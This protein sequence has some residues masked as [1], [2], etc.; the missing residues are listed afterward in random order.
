MLALLTAAAAIAAAAA[1]TPCLLPSF[2]NG[3]CCKADNSQVGGFNR[4]CDSPAFAA[5]HAFCNPSLGHPARTAVGETV[6]LLALP[7][8]PC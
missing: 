3:K 5:A 4:P 2:D 8:H 6:N 1:P 7:P